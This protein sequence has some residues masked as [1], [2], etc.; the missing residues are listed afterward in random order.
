MEREGTVNSQD[1]TADTLTAKIEIFSGT[2]NLESNC[3]HCHAL[4]DR[5][6]EQQHRVRVYQEEPPATGWW[7]GLET[8]R[9][10]ECAKHAQRT[11]E[12]RKTDHYF[13][14]RAEVFYSLKRSTLSYW[15]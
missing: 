15:N 11:P 1:S 5:L 9:R 6:Q 12:C 13:S 7:G 3:E 14:E 8:G 10:A 4:R 2:P